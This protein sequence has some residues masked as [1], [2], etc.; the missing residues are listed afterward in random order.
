[1]ANSIGEENKK[2]QRQQVRSRRCREPMDH[3]A[4]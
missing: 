4:G 2:L 1:M 3:D